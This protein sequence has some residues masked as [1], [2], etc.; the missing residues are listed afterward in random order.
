[1]PKLRLI[2]SQSEKK[3]DAPGLI[4]LREMQQTLCAKLASGEDGATLAV[5]TAIAQAALRGA[6]DLH[7]EP[8]DD[9]LSLKYRIDG[10]LQDVAQLPIDQQARIIARI[11]ILAKIVIYHRDVPQDGRIE[12]SATPCGKGMRVSTFPTVHGEKAVIRIIDANTDLFALDALGFDRGVTGGLRDVLSKPQGTLLLTGPSSSGKTTTIY[13]LL[14]ELAESRKPAPHI[15]TVEDPVEYRLGHISQTE[16][17][18]HAGF[19]FEAALRALLR[20]D[21]EVIMLGEIRDAE[22]ARTAIQAGLTGHLVISTIHSGTAAGVFTRLLD[23]GI[24]PFLVASSITGVLAQRLLRTTCPHCRVEYA[25][26]AATMSRF[27]LG[28]N[29]GPFVRGEGCGQCEGLGYRGRMAIGEMLAMTQRLS[30]LIL[31]RSRTSVLEEAVRNPGEGGTPMR[32]LVEKAVQRV[33]EGSTTIEEV[34]RVL[35]P[36]ERL[37]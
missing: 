20:Q 21:P 24:E 35:T 5:D 7:F 33:R 11:K 37:G 2:E 22:T 4:P 28:E 10:L 30:E 1:M 16:V 27:G 9:C 23:M 13:A 19:T 25:P 36:P 15:V 29:D 14:R 32:T 34:A 17:R 31:E 18:P 8:W 12:P 6:S 3:T 26:D